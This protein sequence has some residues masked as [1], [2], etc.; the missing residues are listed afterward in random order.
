MN[1][2]LQRFRQSHAD[3]YMGTVL[4]SDKVYSRNRFSC[5][6]PPHKT[7]NRWK[8]RRSQ[9]Y[10]PELQEYNNAYSLNRHLTQD[11]HHVRRHH[12]R[13]DRSRS[14]S[15]SRSPDNNQKGHH[16]RWNRARQTLSRN[17]LNEKPFSHNQHNTK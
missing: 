11:D 16:R 3:D 2:P 17:R 10:V 8:G 12:R 15:R 6:G 5:E 4:E 9:R 14:R 13:K 1:L 7:F